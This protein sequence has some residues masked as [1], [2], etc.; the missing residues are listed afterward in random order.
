MRATFFYKSD[1]GDDTPWLMIQPEILAVT[2]LD[3]GIISTQRTRSEEDLVRTHKLM[4]T[5]LRWDETRQA[6]VREIYLTLK[7]RSYITRNYQW[8]N[9]E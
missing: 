8:T 2:G 1:R 4:R 6:R 5:R 9:S 7:G 3:K